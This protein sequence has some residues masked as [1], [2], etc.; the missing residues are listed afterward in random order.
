MKTQS[1]QITRTTRT[2][3]ELVLYLCTQTRYY[4]VTYELLVQQFF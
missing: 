2:T 1:K 3:L 4:N